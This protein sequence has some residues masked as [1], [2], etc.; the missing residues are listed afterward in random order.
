M[1]FFEKKFYVW[2]IKGIVNKL[3]YAQSGKT[4]YTNVSYLFILT[5]IQQLFCTTITFQ[6]IPR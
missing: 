3:R 5:K 6:A 2:Q 4:G 1:D